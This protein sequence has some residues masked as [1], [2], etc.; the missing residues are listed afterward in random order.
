MNNEDDQR[1]KV[2]EVSP[3]TQSIS[4]SVVVEE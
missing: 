2:I 4:I 3:I 1:W